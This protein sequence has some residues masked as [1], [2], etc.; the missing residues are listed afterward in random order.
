M[1]GIKQPTMKQLQPRDPKYSKSQG[2][3]GII[4]PT[5]DTKSRERAKAALM[6][7]RK[8]RGLMGRWLMDWKTVAPF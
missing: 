5:T 2:T 3:S 8:R 4:V 6:V 1:K 7:A